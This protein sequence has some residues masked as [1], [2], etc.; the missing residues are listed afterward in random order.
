MG[1]FFVIIDIWALH[2]GAQESNC[3]LYIRLGALA[4]KKQLCNKMMEEL[5]LCLIQ[6]DGLLIYFK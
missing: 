2:P 3:C 6:L 5:C 4:E 1:Q